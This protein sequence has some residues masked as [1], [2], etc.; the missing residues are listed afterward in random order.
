MRRVVVQEFKGEV[1]IHLDGGSLGC[2][3]LKER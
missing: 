1:R 2:R 3:H